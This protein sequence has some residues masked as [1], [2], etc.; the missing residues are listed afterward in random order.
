M[1]TDRR[2]FLR[3]TALGS[4]S[5]AASG[6]LCMAIAQTAT[7][8]KIGALLPLTG[9]GAVYG[10]SMQKAMQ[11]AVEQV[12]SAGG[13][14]GR[15]IELLTEDDQ[16][17]PEAGV[18]AAKKLIDVNGVQAV[19]GTWSSGVTLAVMPLTLKANIIQMNGSGAPE[20][21]TLDDKDMVWRFHPTN[22]AFGSAFAQ[23]CAARGFKTAALMAFNNAFGLALTDGFRKAWEKQ[24]K[25]ITERVV[26]EGKRPSYRSEV[27]QILAS[28]P[29]VVV[30]GSY[31]PDTTII[32]KEAFQ[33]GAT[34]KWIMPSWSGNDQLV[35]ALG[36]EATEGVLV[37]DTAADETSLAYEQFL[38][39]FSNDASATPNFFALLAYDMIVTI[40]LAAEAAG[41]SATAAQINTK[42]REIANPPGETVPS[43]AVGKA[44]IAKGSKINYEG[45][46]GPLDFDQSG[47]VSGNF[48]VSVIKD[49][50][51]VREGVV[52]L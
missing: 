46:S 6:P 9:G 34:T 15:K 41:S 35:Q 13:A 7:T 42:I 33:A 43:F 28:K 49:G 18:L 17:Q 20:I 3:A 30:M 40:A 39:R 16:T 10:P 27:Q 26:Y 31:L 47:D 52:R 37:M 22:D 4:L 23:A 12:N 14:A 36:K 19:V 1:C 21:S 45:I 44:A 48:N 50:K 5:I 25:T 51:V 32:L 24:R 38:K 8:L 11:I 2:R 29:D